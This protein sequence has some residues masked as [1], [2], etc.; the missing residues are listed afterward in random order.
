MQRGSGACRA[1]GDAAVYLLLGFFACCVSMVDYSPLEDLK[2]HNLWSCCAS[3]LY[4]ART[5]LTLPDCR[6]EIQ[7]KTMKNSLATKMG[8]IRI[9]PDTDARAFFG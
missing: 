1:D 9:K 6:T 3:D 8:G 4:P 5:S 7:C 2:L